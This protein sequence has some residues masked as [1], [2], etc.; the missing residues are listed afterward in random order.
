MAAAQSH[1]G[2]TRW[3]DVNSHGLEVCILPVAPHAGA[4]PRLTKAEKLY[5]KVSGPERG[6]ERCSGPGILSLHVQDTV[7]ADPSPVS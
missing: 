1:E 2:Q 5:P 7:R 4:W 6:R 3:A